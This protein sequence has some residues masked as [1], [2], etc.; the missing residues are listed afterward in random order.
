[1]KITAIR[2]RRLNAGLDTDDAIS[3]L[4]ISK[5]TFYKLEQGWSNPSVSLIRKL[6]S[7]YNCSVDD[8]FSDLGI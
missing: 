5:S 4:G 1:M 6:A 3:S 7:T 8:I 2:L